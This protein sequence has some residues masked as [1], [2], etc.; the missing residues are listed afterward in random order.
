MSWLRGWRRS[1]ARFLPRWR[2]VIDLAM[3][4][5]I[6]FYWLLLLTLS[7]A[8]TAMALGGTENGSGSGRWAMGRTPALG[9]RGSNEPGIVSSPVVT[10]S[11]QI[12][13]PLIFNRIFTPTYDMVRFFVGDGRLYE[14]QHSSGSQ[15]RHQTQ[16]EGGRF[17]HTKGNEISAEWE[18]LWYTDKHIY[19]GTDTSP[20]NGQYYTLRDPGMY[21]SAWAPRFWS[22]GDLFERNPL[23]TFYSKSN[24][25]EYLSGYHRSWL[26][27]EEYHSRFTFQ[28]GITLE[29]VVQ[30]A[31]LAQRGGTPLERYYYAENY[32]LVG[33]WS[34]T[35]GMSYVSE[36]HEPGARPDN[37][38]EVI[39]CLNQSA[40][41][42]PP[43]SHK[44][45]FWPGE[46]RR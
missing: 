10:G 31:W 39:P 36:L 42:M 1:G 12:Y 37:T 45:P 7:G 23:V 30:L 34:S 17:F 3:K 4:R 11:H 18:E 5:R 32:G 44:L 25:S 35:N 28:S 15:A 24:C 22:P 6:L 8:A 13:F 43:L 2:T 19:R 20:G 9:Q 38:R 26:L 33:W 40:V 16:V 27:F 29:E 21:G 14:V 41:S 46:H